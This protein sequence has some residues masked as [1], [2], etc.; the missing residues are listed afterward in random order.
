MKKNI[1]IPIAVTLIFIAKVILDIPLLVVFLNDLKQVDLVKVIGITSL[2]GI[3]IFSIYNILQRLY[4]FILATCFVFYILCIQYFLYY[5]YPYIIHQDHMALTIPGFIVIGNLLLFLL[6]KGLSQ[7]ISDENYS[8]TER[9]FS[10][11]KY[12]GLLIGAAY[13]LFFVLLH[14]NTSLAFFHSSSLVLL[15]FGFFAFINLTLNYK[16]GNE[17]IDNAQVI[18]VENKTVKLAR[19]RFFLVLTFTFAIIGIALILSFD[20]FTTNIYVKYNKFKELIRLFGFYTIFISLLGIGFEIFLRK[21]VILY[22]GIRSTLRMLP[23]FMLLFTLLFLLR[24]YTPVF[25]KDIGSDWYFIF[26]I[27]TVFLMIFSHFSFENITTPTTY[28]FYLPISVETRHDFYVKS[29]VYGILGGIGLGYL[30]TYSLEKVLPFTQLQ[31]LPFAIIAFVILLLYLNNRPLYKHYRTALQEYLNTQSHNVIINKGLFKDIENN[32]PND[33]NGIQFVRYINILNLSN[34]V[35]ARKAINKTINS[36]NNLTQRVSLIQAGELYMLET[37]EKLHAIKSSKYFQ[38]SPNRDKIESVIDRF[39]EVKFRMKTRNYISQLSISKKDN[40]RVFGAKLVYYSSKDEKTSIT[41]RLLKDPHL[42][43]V[44]N[45]IISSQ[46]VDDTKLI[47]NITDNLDNPALSNAA[48]STLLS[49]GDIILPILEES[50]YETGQTE[51]VQLRIIQIYGDIA[52]E[53]TTEYLIKKLNISNQNIISATLSSLSKCSLI[54]SDDKAPMLK[55]ELEELC[56][57][58]VWNMSLLLDIEKNMKAEEL[59][60]AMQIEVDGNY[61]SIFNLLSLLY[62]SR[63]IQLIR[64]N[65]FSNDFEKINF[66]L[67]LSSV[68]LTEEIK[69]LII[70]L[71]QPTSM[72]EK[73][74]FMQDQFP[75]ESL[76]KIDILYTII[77]RDSK[78]MNPWTKA[79]SMVVLINEKRN[80]DLPIFLAHMINS[81]PMLAELAANA[82]FNIDTDIYNNNKRIF[83]QQYLSLFD[84]SVLDRIERLNAVTDDDYPILKY[85]IINYL[86]QITEFSSI[87]GE[88]LKRLTDYILPVKARDGEIIEQVTDLDIQ[89]YFYI[90]YSGRVS[91]YANDNFIKCFGEGTFISTIDLISDDRSNFKLQCDADCVLYRISSYEFTELFTMF[92]I[93][94][95]TIVR[96]T[97]NK[98]L[99]EYED[100]IKRRSIRNRNVPPIKELLSYT[101]N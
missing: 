37:L 46:S 32:N 60:T 1:H 88:I 4:P 10:L 5:A 62:D 19:N 31:I 35:I 24:S 15:I 6:F 75:T 14:N 70:P 9:I 38:S 84:Q 12:A 86:H 25:P 57:T 98:K 13:L 79:C 67:E 43:V 50:F 56:K 58:L 63:S 72:E 47:K 59:Q 33:L 74:A 23:I 17:I 83:G 34:P 82:V 92:Q 48:Y 16:G 3:V 81:D 78:W 76:D 65:L 101:Q 40:E 29:F 55:H 93:V 91:L 49:C 89:N 54:I 68:L 85:E 73:V 7:R 97:I 44:I 100:F 90:L 61:E 2:A 77:Q 26:L 20:L 27:L 53:E 45:A 66:A 36:E 11:S 64:N 52:N 21:K 94:P 18:K 87:S 69:L 22:L 80:D 28:A 71:I 99:L 95:E 39:Y 30:I 96:K 41:N 8:A 42:P 51:K